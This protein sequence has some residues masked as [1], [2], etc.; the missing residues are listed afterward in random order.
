VEA[1]LGRKPSENH[2][3]IHNLIVL[4][5][6]KYLSV[7]DIPL[8]NENTLLIKGINEKAVVFL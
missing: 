1:P 4:L 7:S 3:E 6:K 5:R 8:A 2:D